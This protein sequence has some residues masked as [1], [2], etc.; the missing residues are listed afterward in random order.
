MADDCKLA[1]VRVVEPLQTDLFV[2]RAAVGIAV[3]AVFR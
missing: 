1:V 3:W 2:G